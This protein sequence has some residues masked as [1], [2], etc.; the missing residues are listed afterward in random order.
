[1]GTNLYIFNIFKKYIYIAVNEY[2]YPN[3]W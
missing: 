1:M 3:S 2:C